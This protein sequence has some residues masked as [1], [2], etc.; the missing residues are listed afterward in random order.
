MKDV[1][2]ILVGFGALVLLVIGLFGFRGDLTRK[3]PIE[4]FADM[5]RQPRLRPNEPNSFL[6]GG[7]SSLPHPEGTI[8]R[9][10]PLLVDGEKVYSFQQGHPVNSGRLVGTTNHVE[11]VPIPVT[12]ALV[13]RGRE[14][15]NINCAACHGELADGQGTVE[16][17]AIS[18]HGANVIKM[19]DGQIYRT[20]AW[21][22]KEGTGTMKGYAEKLNVEDRWA[23]VAY[24]RALQFSR[25]ARKEELPTE[26]REALEE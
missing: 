2:Y 8:A 11:T 22:S 10:E 1:K 15:F 9:E 3:P 12:R 26:A 21:G 4:V 19:T 20:I 5:D 13:E 16:I 6:P 14:R 18:L 24:V 17:G 7:S 25:L 23:V